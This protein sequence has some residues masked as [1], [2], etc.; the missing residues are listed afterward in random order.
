M[1]IKYLAR[2]SVHKINGVARLI[3]GIGVFSETDTQKSLLVSLSALIRDF[4]AAQTDF[5][6]LKGPEKL[7]RLTDHIL[8]VKI[9]TLFSDLCKYWYQQC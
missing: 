1:F 7:L 5:I 4:P 8:D 3:Q 2:I 9:L 6:N